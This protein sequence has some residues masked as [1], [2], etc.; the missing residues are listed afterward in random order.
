MKRVT[1]GGHET[2]YLSLDHDLSS[3]LD[4][5]FARCRHALAQLTSFRLDMS[6]LELSDHHYAPINTG[7]SWKALWIV[8]R[9]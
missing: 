4:G 7:L 1:G 5:A 3:S 2:S 9:R 6:H 8:L